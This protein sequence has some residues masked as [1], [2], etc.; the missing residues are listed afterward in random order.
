MWLCYNLFDVKTIKILKMI[1]Y[2]FLSFL[3]VKIKMNG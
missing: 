3:Q 2:M 1:V